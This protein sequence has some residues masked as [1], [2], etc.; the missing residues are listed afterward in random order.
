MIRVIFAQ[1]LI[2]VCIF[3]NSLSRSRWSIIV[4][5]VIVKARC[6]FIIHIQELSEVIFAIDAD[7]WF[8]IK[9]LVKQQIKETFWHSL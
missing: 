2:P 4:E 5:Q 8:K 9:N 6:C 7:L 3:F 1:I